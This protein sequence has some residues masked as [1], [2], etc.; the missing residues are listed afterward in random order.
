MGRDL[1]FLT[2]LALTL[3]CATQTVLNDEDVKPD[4]V[5]DAGA[6]NDAS[7]SFDVV[8]VGMDVVAVDRGTSR[9]DVAAPFDR[10]AALDDVPAAPDR[11]AVCGVGTVRCGDR[12]ADL[13][14]DA[15]N[16]GRCGVACAP[17]VA[18]F[19]GFCEEACPAPRREC[20]RGCTDVG[21]DPEN[22][23]A[24]G[25]VCGAG[26]VCTAGACAT[27]CPSTQT[28]CGAACVSLSV[29]P[30]NCGACGNRCASGSSCV[31]GVCTAPMSVA[32]VGAACARTADCQAG[33]TCQADALGWPGGYCLRDGCTRDAECGA[34]GVCLVGTVRSACFARCTSSAQCRSGYACVQV[35]AASSRL[36]FPS[37]VPNVPVVCGEYAC[38]TRTELCTGGCTSSAQC[39]LNSVCLSGDCY[40]TARTNCGPNR[41]CFTADG[42]CG[43]ANDA[44][45]GP[46]ARCN[47]TTG[48]CL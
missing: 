42:Y 48:E 33:W 16:C 25:N 45:C 38:D 23:G 18:C 39:S 44:A 20:A 29:D 7:L 1:R 11:P 5:E 9:P 17:G 43:C 22:C 35:G 8:A 12:C 32:P 27:R 3:G 13:S 2:L 34:G 36:C 10:G 46:D 26:A 31:G 37:C 41:R 4:P 47:S 19:G 28:L 14:T 30:A 40:C 24:C 15:A 6:V 21:V